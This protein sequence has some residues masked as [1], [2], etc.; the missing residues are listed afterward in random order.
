MPAGV[1]GRGRPGSEAGQG[2]PGFLTR[3]VRRGSQ[4]PGLLLSADHYIA[5]CR[6]LHRP[7]IVG[8]GLVEALSTVLVQRLAGEGQGRAS[9][10]QLHHLSREDRP[11]S[12]NPSRGPST[13]AEAIP[14]G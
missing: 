2:V 5:R 1:M 3:Q 4:G 14:P 12:E 9:T 10:L 11:G 8:A 13:Q 7:R 6:P